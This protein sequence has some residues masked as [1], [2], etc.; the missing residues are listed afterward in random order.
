MKAL[1]T[2]THKVTVIVEGDN[3][4]QIANWASERTPSEAADDCHKNGYQPYED[5]EDYVELMEDSDDPEDE[6]DIKIN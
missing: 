1:V 4:D 5:Y 6:A 3:L 2:L